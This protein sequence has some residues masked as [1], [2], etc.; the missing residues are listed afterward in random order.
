MSEQNENHPLYG[1]REER[2]HWYHQQRREA[3]NDFRDKPIADI[4][5][6]VQFLRVRWPDHE[7]SGQQNFDPA[8]DKWAHYHN[9]QGWTKRYR[10]SALTDLMDYIAVS[11]ADGVP[12]YD[13]VPASA[14][15]ASLR[16]LASAYPTELKAISDYLAGRQNRARPASPTQLFEGICDV[17][18]EGRAHNV[19]EKMRGWMKRNPDVEWPET[20]SDWERLAE[21]ALSAQKEWEE[22]L[23]QRK[24]QQ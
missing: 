3:W 18:I 17:E 5:A 1:S 13:D 14:H 8:E 24:T 10:L 4:W 12:C 2:N 21:D 15:Q 23:T 19:R 16:D 11:G 9:V 20:V 22:T 7:A 6:M